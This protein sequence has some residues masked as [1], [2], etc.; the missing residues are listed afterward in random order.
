MTMRSANR[1]GDRLVQLRELAKV[2]AKT[3]DACDQPALL[4]NLAKQYRETVRDIAE[5]GGSVDEEIEGLIGDVEK[6]R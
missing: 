5:I 1:T 2:L 3:I 6:V 4:P